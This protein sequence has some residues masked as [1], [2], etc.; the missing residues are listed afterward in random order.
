VAGNE[1]VNRP[2]ISMIISFEDVSH[3]GYCAV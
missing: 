1:F 2:V 3:L